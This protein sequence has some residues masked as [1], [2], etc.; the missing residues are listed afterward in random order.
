MKGDEEEIKKFREIV[1]KTENIV[2]Y[3]L[4]MPLPRGLCTVDSYIGNSKYVL[5]KL[6]EDGDY[7]TDMYLLQSGISTNKAIDSIVTQLSLYRLYYASI[8]ANSKFKINLENIEDYEKNL[9]QSYKIMDQLTLKQY[10]RGLDA[11][12][13]NYCQQVVEGREIQPADGNQQAASV[14]YRKCNNGLVDF[15]KRELCGYDITEIS[16]EEFNP[17]KKVEKIIEKINNF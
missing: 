4:N 10:K 3:C 7:L 11:F 8:I 1:T 6:K 17:Y 5:R 12:F 13:V 15:L 2:S 14:A 16:P 9:L